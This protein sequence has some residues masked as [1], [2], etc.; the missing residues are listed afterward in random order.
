MEKVHCK[1]PTKCKR[2]LFKI[3]KP[4]GFIINDSGLLTTTDT[5]KRNYIEIKCSKCG[6]INDIEI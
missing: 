4:S 3:F 5:D 2:L 1:S 6:F